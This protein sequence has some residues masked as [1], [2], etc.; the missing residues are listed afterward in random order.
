[1]IKSSHRLQHTVS[2]AYTRYCIIPRSTVFPL[3]ASLLADHVCTQFSKFPQLR[4][5]PWI[6]SQLLSRLPPELPPP[7]WPPPDWPPPSGPSISLNHGLQV[8]LQTH[9][10]TASKCIYKLAR[11][12][13]PSASPNSLDQ[14]HQVHLQT[15]SIT[16]SKYI[17]NERRQV[18]WDTRVTEVDRVTGSI[19]PAD[20]TVDRHHL[21]SISSY[22]TMKIHTL[23]FPTF[24][25]TRT[26]REISWHHPTAWILNAG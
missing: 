2:T 6:E 15:C 21:I 18:F 12:Q 8:H 23:C 10:I 22:H 16:P 24:G 7:D 17:Y 19:Y 20:P 26:V 3:P 14:S 1:M 25:H 9:S 13:P 11:L 4:V 5:N